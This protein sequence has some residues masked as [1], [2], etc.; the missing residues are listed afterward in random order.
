MQAFFFS[1]R[2][3]ITIKLIIRS[4][5]LEENEN[6]NE[7]RDNIYTCMCGYNTEYINTPSSNAMNRTRSSVWSLTEKKRKINFHH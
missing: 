2:V 1:W 3:I 5:T 7:E 4:R 6:E